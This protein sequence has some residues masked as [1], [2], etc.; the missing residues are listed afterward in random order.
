MN[1]GD[2]VRVFDWGDG[3]PLFTDDWKRGESPVLLRGGTIGT[4]LDLKIED[5]GNGAPL[6][7]PRI[8]WKILTPSGVGWIN[9][10]YC[11]VVE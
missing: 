8:F 9:S 6:F 3:A 4:V 1:P 2:M 10:V 11:E 5:D 7:N